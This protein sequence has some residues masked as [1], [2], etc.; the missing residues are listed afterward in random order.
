VVGYNSCAITRQ[1]YND[2]LNRIYPLL[3]QDG[4]TLERIRQLIVQ[5]QAADTKRLENLIASFYLNLRQLVQ[6][7]GNQEILESINSLSQLVL[8]GNDQIFQSVGNLQRQQ[9][10]N[11]DA[12]QA[13]LSEIKEML[14]NKPLASPAEVSNDIRRALID[15][16]NAAEA[17]YNDGY[18]LLSAHRYKDAVPYREKAVAAVPLP[19]FYSALGRANLDSDNFESAAVA[20][21]NE[22]RLNPDDEEAYNFLALALISAKQYDEAANALQHATTLN[23]TSGT[24]RNNLSVVFLN[25]GRYDEAVAEGLQ[26][27]QLGQKDATFRQT[28][29]TAYSTRGGREEA[30]AKFKEGAGMADSARRDR[31][32]AVAQFKAAILIEPENSERYMLSSLGHWQRGLGEHIAPACRSPQV[33]VAELDC[34]IERL[35]LVCSF[36]R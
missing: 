4:Q 21:R 16:A 36:L 13:T 7:S 12:V 25:L 33:C 26:A 9:R 30:L 15:K 8:S 11:E 1:Q 34:F 2:G 32:E 28:L 29:A 10:A 31:D 27:V 18:A 22:T 24:Y 19:Q 5:G 14:K 3:Q 23:P 17:A 6:M 20:Y 35:S